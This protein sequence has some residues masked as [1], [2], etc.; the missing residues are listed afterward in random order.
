M[1]TACA[2][3]STRSPTTDNATAVR[4]KRSFVVA[5]WGPW[6]L[7]DARIFA[8]GARILRADA[9]R[10]L[11]RTS[12]VVTRARVSRT[13][14]TLPSTR[15]RVN[16]SRGHV[17]ATGTRLLQTRSRV[18]AKDARVGGTHGRV[19]AT[20]T[21]LLQTRSRVEAKD[22]RVARTPTCVVLIGSRVK[23]KEGRV[24]EM[25]TRFA[26]V[27][28]HVDG[29]DRGFRGMGPEVALFREPFGWT[30]VRVT[31]TDQ[32]NCIEGRRRRGSAWPCRYHNFALSSD[33]AGYRRRLR[34]HCAEG[35]TRRT[36]SCALR[37]NEARPGVAVEVRLLGESRQIVLREGHRA[38][39]GPRG[40]QTGWRLGRDRLHRREHGEAGIG[41]L[42]RGRAVRRS[43]A[44][45]CVGAEL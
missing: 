4:A 31:K 14:Q 42:G 10:S 5:S 32:R 40:C 23:A 36:E 33:A 7:K 6:L 20:G 34:G 2:A 1:T 24:C 3:P 18:E 19:G 39:G 12:I 25:G 13:R 15:S 37:E 26:L 17:G 35:S 29:D 44:D 27:E 28:V 8:T 30:D 41:G 11:T 21:R 45:R 38:T 22:A 9:S 16:G 43:H